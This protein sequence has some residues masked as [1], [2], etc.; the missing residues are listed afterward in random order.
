MYDVLDKDTIKFEILP[1]L[2]VAK[3]GYISK[4]DLLEVIQCILYELKSGSHCHLHDISAVLK[5]LL[6]NL[7]ASAISTSGLFLNT[8]AGFDSSK[9]RRT[10]QEHEVFPN[11]AI[12]PRSERKE[13]DVFFDELLYGQRCCIERTNAWMDSYR[14]LLNRFDTKLTNWVAWNYLTFMVILIK[15]LKRKEKSR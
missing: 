15:K 2:S 7:N 14:S 10:C 8:D 6:A 1:H 5:E 4:S 12:Y 3:R 13:D 11:V 9:F